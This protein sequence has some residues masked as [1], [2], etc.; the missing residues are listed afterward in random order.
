MKI[1]KHGSM[2]GLAFL[3]LALTSQADD[4]KLI[5]KKPADREPTTDQEFLVKAIACNMAEV[6]YG[7][8]ALKQASNEE[9]KKFA[10]RMIDDHSKARDAFLE[11]AKERKLAVVQG[12]EKEHQI[13][14]ERLAKLKGEA[15]DREYMHCMVEGHTRAVM[16]YETWAKKATDR[17]LAG[18]ASRTLPK[19]KE[20]LEQARE[21]LKKV[22]AD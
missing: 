7:E 19:A 15:F 20:H 3:V 16:M 12:L 8:R 9:V 5:E 14:V 1:L 13:T 17:D 22:K 2:V 11:H 18:L 21:L 10:Q 4:R 6:K